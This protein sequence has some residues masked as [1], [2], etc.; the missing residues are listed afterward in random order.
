MFIEIS[1]LIWFD[2]G[3][4][5]LIC[6]GG[7]VPFW[8]LPAVSDVCVAGRRIGCRCSGNCGGVVDLE[9]TGAHVNPR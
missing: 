6:R 4:L 1:L 2:S 7:G 8:R 5:W 3:L 9:S